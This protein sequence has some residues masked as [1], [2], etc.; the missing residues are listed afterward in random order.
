MLSALSG[1]LEA[2]GSFFSL[3]INGIGALLTSIG[4]IG[5][6][7]SAGLEYVQTMP[8]VLTFFAAATISLGIIYLI[9]GREHGE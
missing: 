8:S 5:E 9:L 7:T 4:Q 2:I 1:I 6:L 3:L